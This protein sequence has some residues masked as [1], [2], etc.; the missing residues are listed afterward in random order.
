VVDTGSGMNEATMARIFEPFFT[1]YFIGRGMGLCAVRGIVKGHKG[2]L[3]V[4]SKPGKGST[5]E[6]LFPALPEHP[7]GQ[8]AASAASAKTVSS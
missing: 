2:Y 7:N 1:T 3:R 4:T 5:F 8:A 6:A